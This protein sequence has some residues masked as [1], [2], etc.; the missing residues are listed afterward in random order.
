MWRASTNTLLEPGVL[1]CCS[2]GH[3]RRNRRVLIVYSQRRRT[4]FANDWSH[5]STNLNSE[6]YMRVS[7]IVKFNAT[8]ISSAYVGSLL[9]IGC[10]PRPRTAQILL[11]DK[12]SMRTARDC[13][14]KEVSWSRASANLS[15]SIGND[16]PVVSEA[17]RVE[18][19][20]LQQRNQAIKLVF[21]FIGK[22]SF[23]NDLLQGCHFYGKPWKIRETKNDQG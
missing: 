7:K 23:V 4:V 15:R 11:N 2:A 10:C 22:T 3:R 17:A 16:R 9:I 21:F 8:G 18:S 12:P 5:S 13:R 20:F 14:L 6:C 1:E 19:W